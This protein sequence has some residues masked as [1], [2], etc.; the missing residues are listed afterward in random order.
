[1]VYKDVEM[2]PN[3]LCVALVWSISTHLPNPQN[4]QG[5]EQT[6]TVTMNFQ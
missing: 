4:G 2:T 5:Q 6:Q 1:M 3:T